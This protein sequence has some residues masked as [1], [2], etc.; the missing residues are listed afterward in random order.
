MT[1]DATVTLVGETDPNVT[2]TLQPNGATTTSNPNG[3]FAFFNVP[4]AD[5]GNSFTVVATNAAD[6]SSQYTR[7]ITRTQPGLSL[8][9]PVISAQLADDTGV[10]VLDNITSNDSVSGT[11]TA[12]NPVV[13]FEAQL[14]Q[15]SVVSVLGALSGT[16]FTIT[17]ALLSTINGGPVSDGKHTLTLLAKDSNGNLSQPIT[18]SFILITTTPAP[19][20][21]QLLAA[22][23]TGTSSS[24]GV[25]RDTT[26]TFKVVAPESAIV[27]LYANG[28]QVGQ[29]TANNGPVFIATTTLAA[30]TY[31]ITATAQDVAGNVSAA[32]APV[33]LVIST[34]PP[35]TPTLGLDA[36][37]Q[38]TAGQTT[39]TNLPIVNLTGKTDAGVF[40]AL[41]RQWD[42]TTA[43]RTTQADASGDFTF[44]NVALA[45]GSQAFIV[46][47]S[48]VAGNSSELVQ[49]ITTTASDTSAPVITAALANDTGLSS[50]DG[51]TYDP[52]I[53]GL[54]DDPSGVMSFQAALDGGAMMDAT[55]YLSGEG[56]TLTAA[57]LA[58]LN[59]GTA[60]SDGP[61]TVSLQATD[62]LGHESAVFDYSFALESTRPLPPTGVQLLASDLTGTSNT[63]TK[64]RSLT[65]QMSAPT[66]TIVTL[67]MNG[68]QVGQQ[69]AASATLDFAVPGTLA[70]GQYLFTATAGTVSGL[71]SPFSPP[72]TITIDNTPPVI[73]SFGLDPGFEVA[74]V[75]YEHDSDADRA[76]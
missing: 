65:V 38:S 43:I 30:G 29:A 23:D 8:I 55:P 15:S 53:K 35:S 60:L 52:T 62:S 63:I 66:G 17:P 7:I 28:A 67:Y 32:A 69:T 71:V 1:T 72:L 48:D 75:R 56:F 68:T 50:T 20:T 40:V 64:D 59:G 44:S 31:Q 24:D 27:T 73:S 12:V 37:S 42:P 39:E 36:A 58:A 57:D 45:A 21:P 22:S 76:S 14:D 70:D 11:I 54:V 3:L 5:G 18:V 51:I 4:L 33:K 41:Y 13:T 25:T 34:T 10:S 26:P 46:V 61:H 9:A 2:V 49:T 19:V 74:G 47:A 16:T 6:A